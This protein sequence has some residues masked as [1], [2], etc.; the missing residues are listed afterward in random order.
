MKG[1]VSRGKLKQFP[2]TRSGTEMI[3]MHTTLG[4]LATLHKLLVCDA[5]MEGG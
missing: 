2:S 5:Q 4:R 3:T 1:D